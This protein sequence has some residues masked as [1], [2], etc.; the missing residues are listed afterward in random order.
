[1]IYTSQ[2]PFQKCSSYLTGLVKM[3]MRSIALATSWKCANI[4]EKSAKMTKTK[5]EIK[6]KAK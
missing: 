6:I 4:A 3:K 2:N 5:T 1:M